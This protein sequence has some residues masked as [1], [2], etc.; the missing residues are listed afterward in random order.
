MKRACILIISFSLIPLVV[1]LAAVKDQDR[2]WS[3]LKFTRYFHLRGFSFGDDRIAR[4]M[5]IVV[6]NQVQL[7][8]AFGLLVFCPIKHGGAEFDDGAV[9]A[10]Q[11]IAKTETVS[12]ARRLL[13]TSKQN[14]EDLL[15]QL[16]GSVL[17]GIS[18]RGLVGRLRNA[19]MLQLAFTTREA[20]A[21]LTQRTGLPQLAKQHRNELAPAGKSA[22]MTLGAGLS[23]SLF[24]FQTGKELQ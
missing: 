21:N 4:Q 20:A 15:I 2:A 11:W 17:I 22:S 19:E 14:T 24:K 9:D 12:R 23:N 16:P 6:Q 18:E 5:S 1:H 7:R 13:A 3:K 10:Q 8:R